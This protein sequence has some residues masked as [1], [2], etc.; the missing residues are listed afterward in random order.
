MVSAPRM[1]G[2]PAKKQK[3]K[4]SDEKEP[5]EISYEQKRELSD[6]INIMPADKMPGV[7]EIIKENVAVF[8]T[9]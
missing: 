8:A 6:N 1:N 9:D 7:L 2:K 4:R 5:E 3:K